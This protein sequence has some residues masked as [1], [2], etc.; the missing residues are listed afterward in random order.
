MLAG[1]HPALADLPREL[2]TPRGSVANKR[3]PGSTS[4]ASVK[5]QLREA[6]AYLEDFRGAQLDGAGDL[7]P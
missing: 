5:A 7:M 2:L 1:T 4:P 6:R 3:S